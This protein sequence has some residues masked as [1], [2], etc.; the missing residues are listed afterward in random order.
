MKVTLDNTG[1][2]NVIR[3]YV[4]GAIT[5]N[6]TVYTHSVVVTP[7]RLIDDWQPRAMSEL[8]AAHIE[9]IAALAPEVVLLGTG[10]QLRFPNPALLRPLVQAQI[11]YEVMDTGAACRTYNV[12]MGEG[13]RVAAMLLIGGEN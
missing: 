3:A 7:E 6:Q 13:R 12:L 5:I 11:G 9:T 2:L 10:A 4:P 8:T 1:N